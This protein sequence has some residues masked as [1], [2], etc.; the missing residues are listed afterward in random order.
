M[1]A[2]AFVPGCESVILVSSGSG[3]SIPEVGCIRH[4]YLP[5]VGSIA[6]STYGGAGAMRVSS[7]AKFDSIPICATGSSCPTAGFDVIFALGVH[8]VPAG[9]ATREAGVLL[10]VQSTNSGNLI[11]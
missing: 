6:T 9:S 8:S 3:S 10:V 2:R 5:E 11:G 4:R 7:H 1:A